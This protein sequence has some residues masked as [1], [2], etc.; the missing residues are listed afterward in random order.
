[1]ITLYE[2]ITLHGFRIIF[3]TMA[4]SLKVIFKGENITRGFAI[5]VS[6]TDDTKRLKKKIRTF[7]KKRT[8]IQ[9]FNFQ[10]IQI[11]MPENSKVKDLKRR[12][13]TATQV[14]K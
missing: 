4:Y 3:R 2:M 1:M 13:V 8:G 10:D 9:I 7:L 6:P 12:V 5:S 11:T 14:I